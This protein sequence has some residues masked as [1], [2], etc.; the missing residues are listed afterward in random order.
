[1]KRTVKKV[2][3][4]ALRL[5]EVERVELVEE[6]LADLGGAGAGADA[7]WAAEIDRRTREIEGGKVSPVSWG[8]VRRRKR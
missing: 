3:D 8:P 6:L 1:M 4:A 7:A 5:P 2:L